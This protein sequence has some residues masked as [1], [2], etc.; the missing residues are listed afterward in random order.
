MTVE[1]ELKEI[2]TLLSM[3]NKKVDTL[4]ESGE[5]SSIMLL[6][7]RSLKGFLEKEPDI[8]SAGDLKVKYH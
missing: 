3:L 7:E 6:A 1:V 5:A 4:I 2:K 8:Y